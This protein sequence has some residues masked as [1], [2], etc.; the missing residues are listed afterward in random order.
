MNAGFLQSRID[1]NRNQ[2]PE[3]GARMAQGRD[4][5]SGQLVAG[6]DESVKRRCAI[7]KERGAKC[8]VGDEPS[9]Q[10]FDAPVCHCASAFRG[11][12]SQRA[13]HRN[14][15]AGFARMCPERQ[16]FPVID[17]VDGPIRKASRCAE[18]DS[19]GDS[20]AVVSCV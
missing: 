11:Q 7:S 16:E 2:G 18:I 15:R 5:Q 6:F 3:V 8:F 19:V 13:L 17:A 1:L 4:F 12:L 10:N 9:D 14:V 20:G